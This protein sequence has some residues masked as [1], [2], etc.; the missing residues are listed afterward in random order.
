MRLL[1]LCFFMLFNFQLLQAQGKVSGK[2]VTIEESHIS[3]ATVSISQGDSLVQGTIT[4]DAGKFLLEDIPFGEYILEAQFL[5]FEL[6][7]RNIVFDE[8]QRKIKLGN[9]TLQPDEKVLDE[10]VIRGEKSEYVSK[11]DKKIFNVGKDV[12]SQGGDALDVLSQVPQVSVQPTGAIELRG[13][14]SVQILINGRRSGLAAANA[15]DQIDVSN[16]DRIEVI[17]NPSA[18]FDASGTAGIINIILKRA[19]GEGFKGQLRA[20]AGVPADHILL[21][22]MSYK[23]EK[24][25]L[26]GNVRWRYSDYNGR[27]FVNQENTSVANAFS[28]NN[29]EI[30]DRHGL[31][32]Y[33]GGDYYFDD[34]TNFT[35]AYY[36]SNT[37]DSDETN[38]NYLFEEGNSKSEFLRLGNSLENRN[39]NQLETG[40]DHKFDKKGAKLS[41][42][43]QYDFW[44]S[45]KD[46]DLITTGDL[47][48]NVPANL[49]TVNVAGSDDIAIQADLVLP[50]NI[51]K[52][53]FGVKWENRQVSNEYQAEILTKDIWQIYK[54][55]DN[56]VE[57]GEQI[58]AG[59]IN[60]KGDKRGWE[61]M[62][63]LRA[64]H[65]DIDISDK[66]GIY[67]DAKEYLNLFPSAFLSRSLSKS[68][69]IQASFSRRIHRPS[70]WALYPFNELTDVNVIQTGNPALDPS[71]TNGFELSLS[72][73][74]GS[75]SLQPAAYYRRTTDAFES[76]L[77][78]DEDGFFIT[79][80]VNI[81]EFDELGMELNVRYRP[82]DAVS[83][84]AEFNWILDLY[85]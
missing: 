40:L 36:R 7:S 68:T 63:G 61:Y 15:I 77:E 45:N 19:K 6:Y 43:F 20:E 18:A 46:W 79:Q 74:I 29:S 28:L 24:M 8:S 11:M 49:K 4:D 72:S 70:L 53:D 17:T 42:Y 62:I 55:I 73:R 26:F 32:Y 80:D 12:L 3:Y 78:Q 64:E 54:G 81:D 10:V 56:D 75:L 60:Y 9:I 52:I 51:G 50:T 57:Y 44:N 1:P 59:Y 13:N 34:N 82:I 38:L 5:G 37:K 85:G 66:E 83:L 47:P 41:M 30:E 31:G 84:N 67:T 22:S 76:Y 69:S 33:M 65:S 2:L 39:Y 35:M 71:Y 16:I 25:Q 48:Q 23:G 58:T 27:Y 21:P 14:P